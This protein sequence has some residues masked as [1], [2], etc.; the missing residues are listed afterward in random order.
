[1]ESEIALAAADGLILRFDKTP[2]W[3]VEWKESDWLGPVGVAVHA[4]ATAAGRPLRFVS[5]DFGGRD[6]L[7]EYSG[8]DLDW[9]P[10]PFALHTSARAYASR[11]LIVLRIA[12]PDGARNL[13]SA[14]FVQPSVA[15]TFHPSRRQIG[16]VPP[17][18]TSYGHQY[19]E[20]A[21]PVSSDANCAGFFFAPH[22]PSVVEPLLFIAPD[23]RTLLLAPLDGFHEQIISVPADAQHLDD[24]V[25]CGW[26]GDLADVPAGFATELALWAADSPRQALA[27][28]AELL[29]QRYQTQRLTRYADDLVG[30]L[31]Y[32]TDNGAVYYYR[33]EP[34]C[35]YATTLE[36]VVEDMHE[37]DVPIRSL[38]ID[39]W[40][41]PHQNLRPVSTEGA[42]IVPPSGMMRWEPR[43][44]LFPEG[45]GDL[46]KRVGGLALAFH[47]RHFSSASPYFKGRSAWCDGEYAHPA[48]ASLLEDLMAQAA[49]W[50]ASTYE[51]DW[52]VESF[53]GVRGLRQAPGRAR[54]WQESLDRAA[55]EH[56]MHLQWCMS[57]PA[58]FFQSVTLRNLASIRTSGDYRYL[59]DNGLNW[60]WFLHTNALARSLGLNPYKDVFLSHGATSLSDGEAYAE[61]EA[62]LA[63]LSAGPV[64]IGDQ[65]GHSN[66][67]LIL[68]CCREDGVLI[69]PDVPIAAIDRCFHAN[70]FLHP[71][72]LVGECHSLHP[73][74]Y[75][76]YVA[77]FNACRDK[78]TM[79]VRVDL[80]DLGT[81]RPMRRVVVY[82][83]RRR[84]FELVDAAAGWDVEL[85]F[86]DWDYRIVCP[87]LS[88]DMTVFG[89]VAKYAAAG[90]R[91]V[92][93]IRI[94]EGA[95]HFQVR[96]APQTCVEIHGYA[97]RRPREVRRWVPDGTKILCEDNASQVD[98]W[99]WDASGRWIVRVDVATLGWADVTLLAA[100]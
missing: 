39:S 17:G 51:Q 74:G 60:V 99:S 98:T 89:D 55:G 24:G 68:R 63:A 37:R 58:D 12:A 57:T 53:L 81:T 31:S 7:G 6:D 100:V 21:L 22:R 77:A 94:A 4:Q 66:R 27:G 11:S 59:F 45:F 56:G 36:R 84:S 70:A 64:G 92:A 50:G 48:D 95:L 47:S 10:L 26:H 41:Y 2:H 32:W 90:D 97:R 52:M 44:D 69:K 30:K 61:V 72:P 34:G 76:I 73:A 9:S 43:D 87:L 91:R 23:G 19:S 65:I 14:S 25:R 38:Q 40:F 82:D 5:R 88:G 83:W 46:R 78:Q 20:F 15:W 71:V 54:A 85:G 49:A 42:P 8:L 35:D 62:L 93:R 80:A 29:L 96:G 1:M 33:T 3:R 86:Q 16:G 75:W 28:W 79:K 67:D 13:A 18:T